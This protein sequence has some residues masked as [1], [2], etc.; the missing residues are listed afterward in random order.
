MDDTG[1]QMP[2]GGNGDWLMTPAAGEPARPP[3]AR[4]RASS[5]IGLV[6]AGAVA[7][8][9]GVAALQNH[10]S[11]AAPAGSAVNGGI[12]GPGVDGGGRGGGFAGPG[13]VAGE[14]RLTGTL[15][16]VGSST[17]TVRTGGAT[18]TYDVDGATQIVRNGAE[19]TLRG[20]RVGDPVLVHVIPSASGSVHRV[21]RIFAGTLPGDDQPPGD[22]PDGQTP[23]DSGAEA[24]VATV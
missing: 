3:R 11:A 16:A 22:S 20:L 23:D 19:T 7:G 2:G 13:G 8:G 12:T 9:V 17:V 24:T 1:Q 18:A 6:V 21:E 14:Q 4:R 5:V 10:L 15:T